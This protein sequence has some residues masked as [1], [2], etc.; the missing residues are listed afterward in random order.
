MS[1]S[2][3]MTEDVY[4]QV[5]RGCTDS[6]DDD[7]LILI[8]LNYVRRDSVADE[9]KVDL[10]IC[11]D[12]TPISWYSD[13]CTLDLSVFYLITLFPF[14]E[15][16]TVL[17]ESLGGRAVALSIVLGVALGVVRRI[18]LAVVLSVDLAKGRKRTQCQELAGKAHNERSD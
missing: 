2:E 14:S 11:I 17:V 10:I 5:A 6:V 7:T 16:V 9:T 18:V 15:M 1:A 4:D 12:I 13:S 3:R 8:R